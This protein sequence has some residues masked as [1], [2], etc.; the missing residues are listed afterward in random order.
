MKRVKNMNLL[1]QI[2]I[3]TI[4]GV[5][6]G[7]FF[8]AYV[9]FLEIVGTI[10]LRLIQMSIVLLVM[11]QI[12]EAVGELNP[13]T[14]G[15]VGVKTFILFFASSVLAG[16]VGV[17]AGVLFQP[18][19]GI[20]STNISGEGIEVAQDAAQSIGDTILS[21]FPSNIMGALSEGNIVHV[22]V[23]SVLFGL[24]LSYIRVDDQENRILD[25]VKQFNVI[26]LR[27][28]SM[29][30]VI[31]PI[32]IFALIA[33]TIS[34]MGL[35]VI[36]PLLK[37]L[38]V[39]ALATLIYLVI[40]FV[41]ASMVCKVSVI[42]LTK[43]MAEMA[44]MALVTTSSAVTLPT[45]LKDSREKLGI[46]DRVAK[47]VLPLGMTLNSNGSAM[48]MAITVVTIAQIYGVDYGV[49]DY[50]YIAFLAALASLANAVV[51]GA[52]LVSLAIVVPQMNLPIESIA[53]FAGVEWFVGMLR[54]I[55]N[56]SAD[57]T[58]AFIVAKTEDA[59]DY[60]VFNKI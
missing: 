32:G 7:A 59:I 55:L 16:A 26:I 8:G 53:L 10:F 24:A 27:L 54:T 45:A 38:S 51:P 50:I 5:L 56:V 17:L 21:F 4:L 12:I 20:D 2:V 11:G 29:V 19:S 48:H 33:S 57:A 13:K 25:I 1:T 23:F 14:L 36:L 47:L 28:V 22:I 9:G 40:W 49:G 6:I 52:G 34:N 43:N 18:G 3:A 31:A 35:Q 42:K 46:H 41:A 58:T 30:M 60:E 39:Y 15:S 37:Y 44:I